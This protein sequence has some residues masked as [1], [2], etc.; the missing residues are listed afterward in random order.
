MMRALLDVNV[1]ISLFDHDHSLHE[2]ARDWLAADVRRGWAA[3][4]ALGRRSRLRYWIASARC[5]VVISC[6]VREGAP[7]LDIRCAHGVPLGPKV[8]YR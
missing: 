7:S 8:T 3:C 1:L 2:R 6:G 5:E 4:H